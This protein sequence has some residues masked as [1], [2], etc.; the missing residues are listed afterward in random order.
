MRS[1]NMKHS[2]LL[3]L[4]VTFLAGVSASPG[5]AQGMRL[6]AEERTQRLK[7]TL[8]L[9]EEQAGKILAIYKDADKERQELFA[10]GSEDRDARMAAMRSLSE[11]TDTKIEALLT[12]EQKTKYQEL[13][14]QRQMRR[15]Q[16]GPPRRD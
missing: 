13:V 7:D 8:S 12:P 9:N 3:F 14:K 5:L 10:S 2:M 4:V 1:R 15:G 11:K 16:Q 6:S